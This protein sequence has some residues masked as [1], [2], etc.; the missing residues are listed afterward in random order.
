MILL[1]HISLEREFAEMELNQTA[2]E[3]R[4]NVRMLISRVFAQGSYGKSLPLKCT[5][6]RIT[7][8]ASDYNQTCVMLL[9]SICAIGTRSRGEGMMA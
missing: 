3:E 4:P 8:H 9:I 5:N 1:Q 7:Q 2:P 6:N